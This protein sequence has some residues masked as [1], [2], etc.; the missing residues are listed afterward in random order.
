MTERDFGLQDLCRK[1]GDKPVKFRRGGR[2]YV[3]RTR[4]GGEASTVLEVEVDGMR[5]YFEVPVSDAYDFSK[6]FIEAE[7]FAKNL[8]AGDV[9]SRQVIVDQVDIDDS[10]EKNEL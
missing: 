7:I 8:E 1:E 10:G 4:V 6:S 5:R 2:K 3:V 9:I